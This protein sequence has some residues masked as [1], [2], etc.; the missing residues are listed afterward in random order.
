MSS[1]YIIPMKSGFDIKET[2][3]EQEFCHRDWPHSG[4]PSEDDRL[5]RPY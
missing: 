3:G 2:F 1:V 4:S 5:S